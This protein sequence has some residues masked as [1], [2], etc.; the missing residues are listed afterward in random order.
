MTRS[1]ARGAGDATAAV[2]HAGATADAVDGLPHRRG[3]GVEELGSIRI[4][5]RDRHRNLV[6]APILE[7]DTPVR[8]ADREV[9]HGSG[10]PNRVNVGDESTGAR[11]ER[12]KAGELLGLADR[13]NDVTAADRGTLQSIE[14]GVFL[15]LSGRGSSALT[16]SKLPPSIHMLREVLSE[17]EPPLEVVVAE[18]RCLAKE[19]IAL[20]KLRCD[21]RGDGEVAW[22]RHGKIIA[23]TGYGFHPERVGPNTR[24]LLSLPL[25]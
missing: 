23:T 15:V 14:R 19:L 20:L 3:D 10:K 4:R 22:V 21:E 18:K 7:D 1:L 6:D 25:N 16:P 11:S 2:T 12:A 9:T 5:T 13:A 17:V 8:C 24:Q